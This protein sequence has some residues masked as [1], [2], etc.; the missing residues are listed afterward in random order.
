MLRQ[1]CVAWAGDVYRTVELRQIFSIKKNGGGKQLG[2]KC[3]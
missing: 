3:F 2:C 1:Y